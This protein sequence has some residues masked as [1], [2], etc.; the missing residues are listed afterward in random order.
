MTFWREVFSENGSGSSSRVLM[1]IHA[2]AGI[3][4]VS[5]HVVAVPGH[6]LPDAATMMGIGGFVS[7]PYGINAA[8]NIGTAFAG[9]KP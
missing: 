8:R 6:P 1:G 9:P 7:L 3:A 5:Y 2:L 4:W